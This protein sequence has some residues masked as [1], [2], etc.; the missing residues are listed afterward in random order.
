MLLLT[1]S[2]LTETTELVIYFLGR[3]D[4][5]N[6]DQGFENFDRDSKINV[7]DFKMLDVAG[8]DFFM[9]FQ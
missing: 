8:S 7:K 5:M 6:Y 2:L 1:H 4:F 9:I 3:F